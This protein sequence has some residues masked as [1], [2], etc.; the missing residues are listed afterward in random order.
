MTHTLFGA[1]LARTP[2]AGAGRGTTAALLLASNAPDID[3]VAAAGG[4]IKYLQWHRG[5]THGPLGV[6]VLG[7]VVAALVWIG[8]RIYDARNASGSAAAARAG[9]D[10]QPDA[11]F[12]MLVVI[13]MIGIVFH[14]LM[15][16]PT[17]YGTR[18]LSPFSWRWYAVDW[19]PIVDI[20][21]LMVLVASMFGRSNEH[22]RR[23]KAAI[24]LTLMAAN[25]GLRAMAHYQAL[26]LAPQLFGPTLPELCD[27]PPA[28]GSALES[29][30]RLTPPSPPTPGRRC[31]IE[32][33]AIASFTSPFR[34]RIVAQL[35]NAYEIH[36]I[37]LFENRFRS[38]DTESEAPWRMTLRYPNVWTPAVDRAATTRLGQAFLGFSRFPAARS[39]VDSHG[40]TTVRW[41][42]VRFAGGIAGLEQPTRSV[43]PFTA[44]VRIDPNGRILEERIVR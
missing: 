41:S 30:P 16:V 35:S 38:P 6:V 14:I 1:T 13:S 27:P 33:A 20:Y 43:N 24:V 15:D 32:I 31:L 7:V 2:L 29:W 5:P 9:S 26:D 22:Q 23:A 36:D 39:A 21:L 10:P 19:M 4:S 34:W 44:M 28:E 8:R 18:L 12:A 17:S 3:I 42:D 25:Y 11:S 37:D 40:V